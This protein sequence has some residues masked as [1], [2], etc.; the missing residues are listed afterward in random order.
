MRPLL[1]SG[2][3]AVRKAS[4]MLIYRLSSAILR[5]QVLA[6]PVSVAAPPK[7]IAMSD[8]QPLCVTIRPPFDERANAT[9]AEHP[10]DSR[11]R[12][13]RVPKTE[14]GG[15]AW[16]SKLELPVGRK[17]PNVGHLDWLTRALGELVP[18]DHAV[19]S[20]MAPG[21]RAATS[22]ASG[23]RRSERY[24]DLVEIDEHRTA[25]SPPLDDM[26]RPAAQG[27]VRA[28]VLVTAAVGPVPRT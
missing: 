20:E 21:G 28:V 22:R 11:H 2:S 10:F 14:M 19:T 23:A 8:R 26:T 3:D 16:Y 4:D 5:A 18:F 6:A 25:L 12:F 15:Q 9:I 13:D 27:L 7:Q 17:F 24:S 1:S